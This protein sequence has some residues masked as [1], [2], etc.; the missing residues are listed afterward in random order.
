MAR[1]VFSLG[2]ILT[3]AF[4]GLAALLLAAD[5]LY[6]SRHEGDTLHLMDIV[7]RMAAG[8]VPHLDF[9][10]PIGGL[11]FWPIAQ[12]VLAGLGIGQAIL[13]AQVAVAAAL[14]PVAIYVA[15]TRMERPWG[16]VLGLCCL[17]LCMGLVHGGTDETQSISMHYNRWAWAVCFVAVPL[18]L[19]PAPRPRAG[20]DGALLGALM[21]ALAMIKATYFVALAPGI[22]AALLLRRATSTLV[23][24]IACGL[25]L[26]IAVSLWLGPAFFLAYITDLKTVATS[27]TR[28]FPGLRFSQ[29]LSGPPH[30]IGSAAGLLAVIVLRQTGQKT[31]GLALFFLLPGWI[32]ITFQNFGN[33]PQW[34][35]LLAVLL[36]TL[37]PAEG[38]ATLFGWDGRLTVGAI[39]L[40]A[41]ISVLPQFVNMGLSPLRHLRADH[42]EY[43][44][45][46][47]ADQR[48]ANIYTW[49]K[50]EENLRGDRPLVDATIFATTPETA[51]DTDDED[52]VVV[53]FRGHAVPDCELTR[54]IGR[55]MTGVSTD[56]ERAGYG[57]SSRIFV[58]DLLSGQWMFGDFQPVQ[59]AAPW[60]Y[61]GA[62]GIEAAQYM[63]VPHCAVVPQVRS[64]IL[65]DLETRQDLTFTRVRAT[66]A[67]DLYKVSKQAD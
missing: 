14:L 55:W 34:L 7:L 2:A 38:K 63:L 18:A 42:D 15:A 40:A 3:A 46:L 12:G 36:I 21:F 48:H 45:I 51:K 30:L 54:G 17:V 16:I 19:L 9:V 64:E 37:R 32:Y 11:A 41:A 23:T 35:M 62:S 26:T 28:A 24:A 56:L 59:G 27:T 25:A 33:D 4:A 52:T 13:A 10:T 5:G 47:P 29:V 6:I 58:A 60:Y 66:S 49:D 20:V 31:A 50:R 61:G 39:A 57:H 22:I 43:V 8:D 44:S 67:Y 1:S 53:E 65:S